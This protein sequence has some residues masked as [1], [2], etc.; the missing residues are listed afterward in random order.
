[1]L[2][3]IVR[4]DDPVLVSFVEA[5][6]RDRG[7]G[8]AVLDQNLSQLHGAVGMQPQRIAVVDSDWADA[9]LLLVDA[10]LGA[11]VRQ[12]GHA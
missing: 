8:T 2:V 9:R 3:E 1:M 6:L 5:L 11:W 12:P 4:T 10:G 7:I